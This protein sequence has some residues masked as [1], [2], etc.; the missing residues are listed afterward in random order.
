MDEIKYRILD[1]IKIGDGVV[2]FVKG[3]WMEVANYCVL[4]PALALAI[5]NIHIL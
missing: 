1:K 4:S 5:L 2:S 3:G